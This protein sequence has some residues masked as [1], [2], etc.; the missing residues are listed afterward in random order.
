MNRRGLRDNLKFP[1]GLV[2]DADLVLGNRPQVGQQCLEAMHGKA[3]L[4]S[5]DLVFVPR[6]FGAGS[7]GNDRFAFG[8][9]L[10]APTASHAALEPVAAIAGTAAA[11]MNTFQ[12]ICMSASSLLVACL[13][14]DLGGIA[15][16]GVMALFAMLGCAVLSRVL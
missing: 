12:M 9:G 4:G 7:T 3:V 8:F 6:Y 15:V 10:V 1:T 14:P 13:F 5:S 2:S 11:L 16:P